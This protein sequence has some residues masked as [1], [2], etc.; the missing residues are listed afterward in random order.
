MRE[1][2]YQQGGYAEP[3]STR[4][5]SARGGK[6]SSGETAQRHDSQPKTPRTSAGRRRRA[7][8]ASRRSSCAIAATLHRLLRSAFACFPSCRLCVGMSD[9]QVSNRDKGRIPIIGGRARSRCLAFTHPSLDRARSDSGAIA[10][11]SPKRRGA[12]ALS[13]VRQHGIAARLQ[14]LSFAWRQALKC[15][16]FRS[17]RWGRSQARYA[18]CGFES[19]PKCR[20]V[21]GGG[22]RLGTR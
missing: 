18:S 12:S 15:R 16:S 13:A 17:D 3:S 22:Q 5:A 1:E 10:E 4:T 8:K 20:A 11:D 19:V 14:P 7:S 9:R 21:A 6:G 2:R